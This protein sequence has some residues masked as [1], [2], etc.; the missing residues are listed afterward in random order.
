MVMMS[1]IR[2]MNKLETI[3]VESQ[4]QKKF[5]KNI[6]IF[7]DLIF[8]IVRHRNEVNMLYVYAQRP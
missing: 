5:L 4:C 6:N 7:F 3:F 2:K 8:F 1:S